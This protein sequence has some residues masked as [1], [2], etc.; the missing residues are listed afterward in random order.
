VAAV[1][2]A[3]APQWQIKKIETFVLAATDG[4]RSTTL[5]AAT[6]HCGMT[7]E[8]LAAVIDRAAMRTWLIYEAV[9]G[10]PLAAAKV[11]FDGE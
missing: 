2:S 10:K 7:P 6:D 11:M 4:G 3:R 8:E 1:T 5:G 9:A